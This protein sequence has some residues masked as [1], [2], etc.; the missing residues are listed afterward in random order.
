VQASSNPGT[1]TVDGFPPVPE[2]PDEQTTDGAIEI[3]KSSRT[4]DRDHE[5]MKIKP[6]LKKAE[7]KQSSDDPSG[8]PTK[9]PRYRNIFTVK[10]LLGFGPA[11]ILG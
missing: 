11:G 4:Q 8:P 2:R 6:D 5:E 10:Y 3:E 7:T 9:R 1:D